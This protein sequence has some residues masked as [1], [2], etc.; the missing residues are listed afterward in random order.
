M[1]YPFDGSEE[2]AVGYVDPK[3]RRGWLT[4]NV[5]AIGMLSLFSDMG[6]E[7][8]T[9]V[10]PLF[11]A[12]FGGGAAALGMIE[13]ISDAASSL[14]KFW[15]SLYSDR[16]GKR[17]PILAVGYFVTAMMGCF[18]FV[19]A[20]WQ[21][22]V[23]RGV[24]WIGRG[25]RGPVRDA[26]LS[27]SVPPEAHG[28]AFEFEG[29]MD[30]LGAIIG[31][32]IALSLLGTLTLRQIFLIAFLPGAVT[33]FLAIFVVQDVKRPPLPNL[34]LWSSLRS[35]PNAFWKYMAAVS[36]FGLGN[37]AHT[38][39]VLRTIA[40]LSPKMGA[41][42]AGRYGIAL[43]ILHNTFY[44]AVS[45]PAGAV[46]DRVNKRNLLAFGYALFGIMCLLFLQQST[47]VVILALLFAFA[48]IYIGIVDAMERALAAD[49]LPVAQ[50]GVG[51]GALATANSFGDLL[52]SICVGYLWSH[53]SFNAG[54]LY[55]AVFTLLGA[56]ALFFI[57]RRPYQPPVY[58]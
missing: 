10:L 14:V 8:T 34:T 49:L 41:V 20:W 28:R 56:G 17:K 23:I 55:G 54:F 33:V 36:I 7:L 29:A 16:V 42:T 11:L 1:N 5:F 47:N 37:F 57:P 46:G 52:S 6:H 27:E 43:F 30:T 44:A 39:L 12:S 58:T 50:R 40:L 25:A 26:L 31:P 51:Y 32:L 22:L 3:L 35:L 45:Y 2:M 4:R 53:V 48:G 38:L 21:L 9:A 18:A 24:A 15:M 13:G 19:T